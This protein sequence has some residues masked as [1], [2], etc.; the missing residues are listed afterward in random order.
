MV[1]REID[2]WAQLDLGEGEEEVND[3]LVPS[4]VV[5]VR[6]HTGKQVWSH[7][8]WG[9]WVLDM[10][11]F[12]PQRPQRHVR[13]D[14]SRR[15][16]DLWFHNTGVTSGLAGWIQESSTNE[17]REKAEDGETAQERKT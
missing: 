6:T 10:W 3:E 5:M 8:V 15:Q 14:R 9:S 2:V 17:W 13:V 4:S 11:G 1:C 7:V 16:L 12:R